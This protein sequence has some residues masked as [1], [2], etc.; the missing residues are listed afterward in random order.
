MGVGDPAPWMALSR[1]C[2]EEGIISRAR[3]HIWAPI[4]TWTAHQSSLPLPRWTVDQELAHRP[5]RFLQLFL[6]LKAFL[7]LLR[8]LNF[9]YSLICAESSLLRGLFPSC[10]ERGPLC[11]CAAWASHCGGFSCSLSAH[12]LWVQGLQE[13][14][15]LGR[16]A[17]AR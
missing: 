1:R 2:P 16:R 6:F 8:L 10:G 3:K 4:T 15:L 11:S 14:R 5:G 13:L 7:L 17:Q 9:L 12:R